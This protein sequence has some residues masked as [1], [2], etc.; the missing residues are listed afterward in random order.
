MEFTYEYTFY[1]QL[2]SYQF[3]KLCLIWSS[4]MYKHA[5][6]THEQWIISYFA[7]WLSYLMVPK[8]NQSVGPP[9]GRS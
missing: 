4:Y 2:Q 1:N 6:D 8:Q 7:I 5:F 9:N 3:E